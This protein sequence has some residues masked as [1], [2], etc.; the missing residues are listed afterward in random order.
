VEF[1]VIVLVV[2]TITVTMIYPNGDKYNKKKAR[3]E[4]G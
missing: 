2:P 1:L 4:P 3:P